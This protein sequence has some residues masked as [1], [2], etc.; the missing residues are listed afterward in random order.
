[1]P[2]AQ[3][4]P[5]KEDAKKP[6]ARNGDA[7]QRA[8]E[9]PVGKVYDSGLIKR[10]GSYLKPYWWQAAVSSISIS[11][12]SISDIAGPYLLMVGMDR[13]FP[14]DKGASGAALLSHEGGPTAFLVRHLPT[15]PIRRASPGSRS[16]TSSARFLPTC[17]SS[18]RP[19]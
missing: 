6:D 13:Y 16:S 14:T 15:E 3:Q 1:M 17:S 10:L 7:R 9:D 8:D 18:S 11:L 19:T 2:D 4:K 5:R 12:K